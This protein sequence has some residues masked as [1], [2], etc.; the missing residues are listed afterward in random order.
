MMK[1]SSDPGFYFID[2]AFSVLVIGTLVLFVW[3]SM[4]ALCDLLIY[5]T[6]SNLSAWY[7]LVS[8]SS[9]YFG[10]FRMHF[11]VEKKNG[12]RNNKWTLSNACDFELGWDLIPELIHLINHFFPKTILIND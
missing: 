5:P 9:F 4:F 1:A 2:C 3:R 11:L 10:N 6:D 12:L 7:S 8:V